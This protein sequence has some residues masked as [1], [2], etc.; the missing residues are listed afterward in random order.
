MKWLEINVSFRSPQPALALELIADVFLDLDLKGVVLED[1]SMD[2]TIDWAP[3]RIEPPKRPCVIGYIPLDSRE[4]KF[5]RRIEER[6]GHLSTRLEIDYW[7]DCREREEEDWAESWKAFFRPQ[8]VGRKVVVKPTWR[9]YDAATGE[10][11]VEIDPGMAFGTGTH[12]STSLSIRLIENHLKPGQT[13]LDVGCGSGILTVVGARL[14]AGRGVGIDRDVAATTVARENL[15]ANHIDLNRFGVYAGYLAKAVGSRF[16]MVA[17]NIL[18]DV[19]LTLIKDIPRLVSP[20]GTFVC[21]GIIAA[22]EDK[23]V[24][25]LK[26]AGF[27]LLEVLSEDDWVAIA[28]RAV[29]PCSR[30]RKGGA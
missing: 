9:R 15:R 5:R 10:V 12:S 19:I 16:D 1:D 11:V 28:A 29:D 7:I 27:D 4:Q 22:Y 26:S 13:F 18:T 23:V 21:S 30:Q 17:A 25:A 24:T 8:K 3:D 20:G 14:G 2:T 6:L